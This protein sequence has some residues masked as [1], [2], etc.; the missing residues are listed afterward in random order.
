VGTLEINNEELLI[1]GGF[2]DI[3]SN[4]ICK[5]KPNVTDEGEIENCTPKKLEKNDFFSVNGIHVKVPPEMNNGK[6]EIIL[7]GHSFIH[8]LDLESLTTKTFHT[9]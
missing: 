4:M 8:C 5:Y 1:Y 7:A 3:P 6:R 9:A 2:T